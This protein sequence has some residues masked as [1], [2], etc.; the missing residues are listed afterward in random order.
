MELR[1][2]KSVS[3]ACPFHLICGKA[4]RF[5]MVTPNAKATGDVQIVDNLRRKV[6]TIEAVVLNRGLVFQ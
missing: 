2:H 4:A 6:F 1:I 5:V 3:I